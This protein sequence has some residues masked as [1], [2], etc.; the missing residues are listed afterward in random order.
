MT[1]WGLE[2]DLVLRCPL[3]VSASIVRQ[4]IN[5]TVVTRVQVAASGYVLEEFALHAPLLVRATVVGKC[6]D[7]AIPVRVENATGRGVG[8]I[9]RVAF[10]VYV[11]LLVHAT[12]VR[13]SEDCAIPL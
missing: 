6:V 3:L 5:V 10:A 11:P 2:F 8:Q 7:C 9:E 4:C 13:T 1:M 12:V